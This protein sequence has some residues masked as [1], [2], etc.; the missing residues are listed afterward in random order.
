MAIVENPPNYHSST[1]C[2]YRCYTYYCVA[3]YDVGS[4]TARDIAG[5]NPTGSGLRDLLIPVFG[6]FMLKAEENKKKNSA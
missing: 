5:S 3:P 6:L 2:L 4:K 1:T